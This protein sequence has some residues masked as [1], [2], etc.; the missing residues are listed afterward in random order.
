MQGR[1]SGQ[2]SQKIQE[3]PWET[4][5]KEFNLARNL[6]LDLIE[7]TVDFENLKANPIFTPSGRHRLQELSDQHNIRIL[8]MTLDN[9]VTAP[10]H[11]I[12]SVTGESSKPDDFQWVIEQVIGTS[13][14]TLVLPI[15]VE[16]GEENSYSL[17]KLIQILGGFQPFLKKNR[18]RVAL[19]CELNLKEIEMVADG[20]RECSQIGFNFDIGNSAAIGNNPTSEIDLFGEKLFN[21]HIKDRMLGGKTVPIGD[22]CADFPSIFKILKEKNYSGNY[23]L[24]AARIPQQGESI[25]IMD[26]M[27]R[28]EG[29]G[30]NMRPL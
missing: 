5:E 23:I 19:E 14:E 27:E 25:T 17:E 15:V 22:G 13:V 10:I 18:K 20:F 12:N 29:L 2:V 1:L 21:V 4:W 30:L 7:W 24:Q 3:F 11:K 26:Y 9:F 8:S 6:N 16:S 28:C